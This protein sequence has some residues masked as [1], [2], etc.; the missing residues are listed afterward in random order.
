MSGVLA[1]LVVA[2]MAVA[3][4]EAGK[5]ATNAKPIR[6]TK[7]AGTSK[8]WVVYNK[9]T[10]KFVKVKKHPAKYLAV[11]RK[12][13]KPFKVAY[14]P[15]DQVVPFLLKQNPSIMKT[16]KQAGLRIKL[17][18]NQ[19]P[20][21]TQPLVVADAAVLYKPDVVLDMNVYAN[22]YPAIM[23]KYN[24]ACLPNI[25]FDLSP[26][27]N[28]IFFGVKQS[29][30]GITGAKYAVQ[31][32]KQR[33]WAL[34]DVWAVSCSDSDVGTAPG[35][36]YDRVA[37]F[38]KELQKELPGIPSNQYELLDCHEKQGSEES[39]AKLADWITAHPQAKYVVSNAINDIRCL[40]MYAAFKA[41]NFGQR[42]V[43][44]GIDADPA[45]LKLIKSGDPTFV[46]SVSQFPE[47][48]GWYVVPA[49]IDIA[50]G[51]P[52]PNALYMPPAVIHK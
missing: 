30:L 43:I 29:D 7:W 46:G 36:P 47:R 1:V 52:V 4:A 33:N 5:V 28:T 37:Y 10:C 12:A 41:A 17:F 9:K 26:P 15:E 19:Y 2:L 21:T 45:A 49:A 34:K 3:A 11:L 32:I 18:D 40:G 23:K 27:P 8:T 20:S 16:A 39:R 42:A 25:V 24:A 13:S 44:V 22:L 50:E 48:R 14:T 31:T 38:Q 35:S 51:K 6:T